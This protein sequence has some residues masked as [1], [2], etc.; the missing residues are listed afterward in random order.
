MK[1]ILMK[2]KQHLLASAMGLLSTQWLFAQFPQTQFKGFGHQELSVNI[3]DTTPYGYFGIGEHDFFI[4]SKLSPRISFLGEYVVRPSSASPS[5]FLASIE[6]S[7]VKFNYSGNHSVIA[8]K[9]HTPLNYWNDVYH[10]G[11]LFFPSI[12]RP[13]AFSHL[14][15]VHTLGIQLQG[16]NL[17]KYNFGYDLGVGN[18]IHNTDLGDNKPQ[19]AV[20]GAVHAKPIDGLRVGASYYFDYMEQN[21]YGSHSGH[22]TSMFPPG[23][24]LYKGKIDYHLLSISLAYFGERFELLNEFNANFTHTDSL[25]LAKNYANYIYSAFKIKEKN[26]PYALFDY[27]MVD[28]N[29]LHNYQMERYK[30]AVGYRYEFSHLINIKAQ[31]EK[32]GVGHIHSNTPHKHQDEL[33]LRFQL[34]YGF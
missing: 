34:A 7:F 30:L 17:G 21:G 24:A 2:R 29:D 31:I 33:L 27:I 12:D 18:G 14:I 4:T 5:G 15:P 3:K 19:H 6:R 32:I 16:Q 20:Y 13:F 26:I 11:R 23:F 9:V 8:G 1:G 28:D 22:S 25:G 10:H